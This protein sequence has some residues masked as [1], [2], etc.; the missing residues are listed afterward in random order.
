[1]VESDH[2]D[3]SSATDETA[4]TAATVNI[5]NDDGLPPA[6][7]KEAMIAQMGAFDAG[8]IEM[9]GM[10]ADMT[11]PLI[12]NLKSIDQAD[13]HALGEAAHSLKGGARSA[14]C[15]VL[16]DLASTLQDRAEQQRP[17]ETLVDDIAE[18]FMRVKA[19]INDLKPD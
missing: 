10:F 7:D 13:F 6:I 19:T 11:E 12:E 16:G 5:E 3:E 1:M 17:P 14:C 4:D 9:L 18:E 8:T 2:G 15:N